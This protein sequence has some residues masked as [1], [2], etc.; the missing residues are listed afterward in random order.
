[1]WT[2]RYSECPTQQTFAN[3]VTREISL[4]LKSFN[5]SSHYRP[6]GKVVFQK[7]LSVHRGGVC[8]QRAGLPPGSSASRGLPPG[9][10]C[11]PTNPVLT[12]SGSY[13]RSRYVFYWNAFL[14]F[15]KHRLSH[16]YMIGT[17]SFRIELNL[18][19]TIGSHV[20]TLY[21]HCKSIP[22]TEVE[23]Y[24]SYIVLR[25]TFSSY[26]QMVHLMTK[27]FDGVL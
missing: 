14:F 9:R 13:Y 24:K 20:W 27:S 3:C 1:M 17:E 21:S 8:L 11:P 12:Y 10:V 25:A 6:Q 15:H 16:K 26:N 19:C 2:S 5:F 23:L 7:C 22:I 18:F 4:L